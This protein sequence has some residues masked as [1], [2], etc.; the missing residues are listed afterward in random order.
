MGEWG[1]SARGRGSACLRPVHGGCLCAFVA[2]VVVEVACVGVACV[3]G[4][5][6]WEVVLRETRSEGD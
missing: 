6:E 5:G 4:R 2:C 3:W 1:S